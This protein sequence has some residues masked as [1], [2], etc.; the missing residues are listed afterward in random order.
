MSE[1]AS[2]DPD[3]DAFQSGDAR[4]PRHCS[5]VANSDLCGPKPSSDSTSPQSLVL[6]VTFLHREHFLHLDF[7]T[8]PPLVYFTD[9]PLPGSSAKIY[10]KEIT[11]LQTEW[12]LIF[13][14]PVRSRGG[15]GPIYRGPDVCQALCIVNSFDPDNQPMAEILFITKYTGGNRGSDRWNSLVKGI[16][17]WYW[18]SGLRLSNSFLLVE[19]AAS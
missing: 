15:S 9:Y 7:G 6:P 19:G 10:R 16:H 2:G 3:S 5:C 1:F 13:S 4:H 14:V 18:D 17:W 8:L 11:P 12:L